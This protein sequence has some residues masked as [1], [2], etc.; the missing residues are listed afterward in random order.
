VLL[1]PSRGP[2][3]D[4]FRLELLMNTVYAER[5]T[6]AA[7]TMSR[8]DGARRDMMAFV[9]QV[10]DRENGWTAVQLAGQKSG[11]RAEELFIAGGDRLQRETYLRAASAETRARALAILHRAFSGSAYDRVFLASSDSLEDAA[12][13]A[14][15]RQTTDAA[16]RSPLGV[17]PVL[18]FFTRL[19]AEVRD[20]R[21]II[22]R[23][24]AQAPP[25]GAELLVSVT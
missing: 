10:I 25:G 4:L 8:R 3:P 12:L 7:H 22:W 18:A 14:E 11:A 16:R 24:A 15:L 9:R 20:L 1:A 6:A 5:A 21:F 13:T 19:R 23:L 2:K 17:A